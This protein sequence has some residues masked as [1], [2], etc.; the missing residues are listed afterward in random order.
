MILRY[1]DKSELRR[2]SNAIVIPHDVISITRILE[3]ERREEEVR[4]ALTIAALLKNDAI[5]RVVV[6]ST[7]FESESPCERH[8]RAGRAM[9]CST[10]RVI[11]NTS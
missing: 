9:F 3:N 8:T 7:W 2:N 1:L 5:E 10:S 11:A 6:S 4:H